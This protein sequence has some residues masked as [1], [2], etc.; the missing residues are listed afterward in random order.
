M[1]K[2]KEN[3]AVTRLSRVGFDNC[4]GY[5]KGGVEKWEKDG[6]SVSSLETI[7]SKSFIDILKLNKIN[8]LDVRKESE[9]SGKHI[10][11]ATNIPLRL[12]SSR[13]QEVKNDENLYVHC[14]GGYRSVI[15]LSLI[16]I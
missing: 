1:Q 3:E 8:I 13:F 9:F 15:A 5:L 14:A 10:E 4:L 2:G 16:H 11:G 6:N 7:K 12:L